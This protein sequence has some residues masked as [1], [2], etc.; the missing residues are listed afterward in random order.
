MEEKKDEGKNKKDNKW[1][2]I[3]I[4]VIVII[5]II[6]LL[7]RSCGL[8]KKYKIKL[9]YGDEVVEVDNN[10]KLSDLDVEGGKI[11]F[12]VDSDG[13]I[14]D[15][16]SKLDSKK[17]YS[18][19]I[20]PEGKESV[21][22][23]YKTDNSSLT[24]EYQKEAGL[25][26]PE[27]PVKKGYV[28]IGWKDESIDD[29]P[30]YMMPV[31]HDMTLVAVF[32][33]S[34]TEDGKCTL[35][36]DTNND[37]KCDLNCDKN[38]D[39]K[40]D[41]NIDTD[42]D[43]KPD[44]NV[45]PDHD[46]KCN[47]NCDKDGDGKP[48]TNIDTDGDGLCD[49]NCNEDALIP[50]L[51]DDKMTFGCDDYRYAYAWFGK[52][53]KWEY[54]FVSLVFDGKN[55]PESEF[56]APT[57]SDPKNIQGIPIKVYNY[58]KDYIGSGK[59]IDMEMH[60]IRIDSTGQ[61]YYHVES[62]KITFEGNCDKNVVNIEYTGDSIV[63][64]IG[65]NYIGS[66]I[67]DLI[68][69]GLV[70]NDSSTFKVV[71]SILDGS[72]DGVSLAC[73]I[74]KRA[75]VIKL[76][77]DS[78]ESNLVKEFLTTRIGKTTTDKC[79]YEVITDG[80]KYRITYNHVIR[81]KGEC[82]KADEKETYTLT[83][84]ANGG[85]VS[86]TSKSLKDGEVYGNLPT[87]TRSG[88]KFEGWY[89]KAS[90][91]NKVSS[92]TKISGNTTIYAHWS[93][94]NPE[95]T[96]TPTPTPAPE[97]TPTP[98]PQPDNGTISLSSSNTC[99]IKGQSVTVTANVSNTNNT[100]VDWLADSCLGI[101]SSGNKATVTANSCGDHPAI[102]GRLQNGASDKV[103]FNFENTLN[104]TVTT[105]D[106]TAANY[107]DGSYHGNDLIITSNVPAYITGKYLAGDSSSLRTSTKTQGAS[108]TTVTIKTPCGQT[109]TIAISA[110]IN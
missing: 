87:P 107:S 70:V 36:C 102:T 40:P 38:G 101:T 53:G 73:E 44:L 63:C 66:P 82:S 90:G 78:S 71:D 8:R 83:Y 104:V 84:N 11:S 85:S 19:H 79:I 105:S 96:P 32:E 93:K 17:E 37:G 3:V 6:L 62:R 18:A 45:D 51:S 98:T 7:L 94:Q 80:I 4:A 39:G 56:K 52:Y 34:S 110:I 60:V 108:G 59:T 97:P 12:L 41:T 95:P 29:Y 42:G 27:D 75:Y 76:L 15:P 74:S 103:T 33:K 31:E 106:G 55:I 43:G 24:I 35:N 23:T 99:L 30:I 67:N 46:G 58:G 64:G 81:N 9:H 57:E 89:T 1:L 88:F 72:Y 16:K 13:H 22:V 20:I 5:I 91:G 50:E 21:K 100:A 68:K 92:S 2:K 77:P 69:E 49:E 10:F 48:D 25:L 109:K 26:F 47:L 54:E 61:K 86:Q 65:P 28:F 14:V